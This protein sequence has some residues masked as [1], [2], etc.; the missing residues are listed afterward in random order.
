MVNPI[1]IH[2]FYG[3][4]GL[5]FRTLVSRCMVSLELWQYVRCVGTS[6][7]TAARKYVVVQ[8]VKCRG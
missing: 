2:L 3:D 5:L 6:Q 7:E 4:S 8:G 1:L